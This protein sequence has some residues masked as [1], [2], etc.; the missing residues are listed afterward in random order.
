MRGDCQYRW[1]DGLNEGKVGRSGKGE[2]INGALDVVF[3]DH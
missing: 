3:L 1:K 2:R